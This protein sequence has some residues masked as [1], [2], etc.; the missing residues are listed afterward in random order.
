MCSVFSNQNFGY[1]AEELWGHVL[2]KW[3]GSTSAFIKIM[4]SLVKV[5][6]KV[7]IKKITECMRPEP[8]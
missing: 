3:I 7:L 2:R 8:N 4:S 6:W 5:H 1:S